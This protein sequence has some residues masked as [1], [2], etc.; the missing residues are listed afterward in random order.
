MSFQDQDQTAKRVCLGKIVAAHGVKGLVKI[1]PFGGDP[2]LIGSL[3]PA[4]TSETGAEEI[5]ITL[6][7]KVG[8]YILA[9]IGGTTERNG[10]EALRGTELYF[11][12]GALPEIEEE[13]VF[14]YDQLIGLEV[15]DESGGMVG[16]VIAVEN[17]GAGDLIEIRPVL[18][19]AFYVPFHDN[20]VIKTNIN[21]KRITVGDIS[22][23][24]D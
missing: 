2:S 16:K 5:S 18:G 4:Y 15:V 17:F 20:F 1:L 3:K 9:E 7:N 14:Y 12:R 13:G 11:E 19:K 22:A 21:A 24:K 10:A 23:F 8:K 6:K